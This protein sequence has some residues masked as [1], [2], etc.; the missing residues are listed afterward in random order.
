MTLDP[1]LDRHEWA[2]EFAQIEEGMHDDPFDALPALAE[3]VERM[4]RERGFELSPERD[5]G[6]VVHEFLDA[7]T[8]S[9]QG[10]NADPGDVAD[11]LQKLVEI[12]RYL[13][14]E[15]RAP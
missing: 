2:T 7:K 15:R 8:I 4:L 14:E 6:G 5:E 11:A 12:Y 1:G 9:E 10:E 3:L 13:D